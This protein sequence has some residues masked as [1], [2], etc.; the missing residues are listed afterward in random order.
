MR[1]DFQTYPYAVTETFDCPK[2]GKTKR[3]RTF[4]AEC[5]VN[6]FNKREDGQIRTPS[7]VRAQSRA[8]ALREAEQFLS[9]PLCAACEKEL[10]YAARRALSERRRSSS[11]LHSVIASEDTT[12]A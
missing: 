11:N 10:T 5:T 6:P 3:K 1:I 2:C 9:E 12:H 4:R 7:E 8:S